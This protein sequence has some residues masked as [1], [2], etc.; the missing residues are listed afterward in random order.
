MHGANL[1]LLHFLHWRAGS[2]PPGKPKR[3]DV[4]WINIKS[5]LYSAENY[6]QYLVISHNGNN[7]KKNVCVCV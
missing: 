7:I 2:L 6:I 5:P 4:G 3:L 1:R